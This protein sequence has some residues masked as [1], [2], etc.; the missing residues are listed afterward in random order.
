M[1]DALRLAIGTLTV[2]HVPA[3]RAVT[4]RVAGRAMLL[5]PLVGAALGLVAAVVLDVVRITTGSHRPSTTVDLLA[6]TLALATLAWL[7]RAL[8][9]DGLADVAGGLGVKGD[10]DDARR[11]RLTVMREP[12]VGAFGVVTVVLTLLVQAAALTECTVSGFGTVSLVVAATVGRLGIVWCCT[13]STP[14]ARPDGLGAAVAGTVRT[15]AAIVAT[16]LVLGAAAALG[17]VDDDRGPKVSALLAIAVLGGLV[18]TTLVRRRSIQ[19]F[20][21][22]TGDVLGAVVELTTATVLV[23]VALGAGLL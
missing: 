12:D 14:S 2:V 15:R 11:R 3:P 22:I 16:V 8:H 6:A 7:T 17:M 13:P 4:S 1:P 18:M 20:G 10:G 9:L 21:G 19:R 5:A 23:V